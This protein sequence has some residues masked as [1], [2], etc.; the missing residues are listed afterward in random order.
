MNRTESMSNVTLGWAIF[1]WIAFS[2][3]NVYTYWTKPDSVILDAAKSTIDNRQVPQRQNELMY[4]DMLNKL[5]LDKCEKFTDKENNDFFTCPDGSKVSMINWT[6]DTNRKGVVTRY[7]DPT[8]KLL[9]IYGHPD[10]VH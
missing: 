9:L 10:D 1:F 8:G 3:I 5:Q 2:A 6:R 4:T 7:Y